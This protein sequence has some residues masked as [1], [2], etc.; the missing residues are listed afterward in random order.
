[1]VMNLT[2]A[3]ILQAN[4]PGE[5]FSGNDKLMKDEYMTLVK[6][7][8]PDNHSGT[9]ESNDIM[10]K[11]NAL[12][13]KGIAQLREGIWRK[14]GF[15]SILSKDGKRHEI[16]Y[17]IEEPFEL[18]TCYICDNAVVY[19]LENSFQDFYRNAEQVI[20]GFTY[21]DE[22]MHYEISG[23]LPEVISRFE[24]VNGKWGMVLAKT[25]DMLRLK[26]I[27]AFY[28]G[29]LPD[30][31]V[32]WIL[33]RLYNLACYLDFSNLTHNAMSLENW[34][35]SPQSHKGALLGGW[36]YTVPRGEPMLGVPEGTYTI[37]P[38]QVRVDKRGSIQTDLECIRSMGRELL[39]DRSGS[40]LMASNVPRAFINWLRVAPAD[41]AFEEYTRWEKVLTKSYGR[42]RF[43]VMELDGETL[44]EKLNSNKRNIK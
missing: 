34:F 28:G 36:W 33:S 11:I 16:R 21:A 10:A 32:A 39:G 38:P 26:D 25:P 18:G 40:R 24:T 35:V 30:R 7:W 12:Y 8:H 23:Y 20:R 19:L 22:Q 3:D 37:L 9:K 2:A 15:I 14:P 43:T 6:H 5:L 13:E 29:E 42:R 4:E 17:L 1:M 31:H 27:L 44:Y 41:T